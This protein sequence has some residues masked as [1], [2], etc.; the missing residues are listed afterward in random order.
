MKWYPLS[1]VQFIILFVLVAIA[2]VF[3]YAQKYFLPEAVRPFTYIVFIIVV[4]LFF[5]FLVRPDRPMVLAQTLCLILGVLAAILIILQDVIL[6]YQVSWKTAVVFLGAVISPF[7][8]G[9]LYSLIR[10]G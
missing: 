1:I 3:T 9:Y 6:I 10:K 7:I 4:L 5:F 8:A 2:D